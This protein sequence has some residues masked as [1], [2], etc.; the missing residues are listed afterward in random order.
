M[1]YK[2]LPY[3]WPASSLAHLRDP[4]AILARPGDFALV[5]MMPD[6]ADLRLIVMAADGRRTIHT[7]RVTE[8]A[9][10]GNR[11]REFRNVV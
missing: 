7:R 6:S 9:K 5:E 3:F 8:L 2:H 11:A 10:G 1:G 4:A